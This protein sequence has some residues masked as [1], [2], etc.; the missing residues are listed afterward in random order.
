MLLAGCSLGIRGASN[1]KG[2]DCGLHRTTFGLNRTLNTH[3]YI[4]IAIV[5]NKTGM[6]NPPKRTQ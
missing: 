4:R 5:P 2:S 3:P 6:D 1:A